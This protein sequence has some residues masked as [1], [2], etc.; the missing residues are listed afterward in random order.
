MSWLALLLVPLALYLAYKLVGVAIK[1]VL[2]VVLVVALYWWAAPLMGWPTVS[3]LFYVFGPDFEG[4]RI[5]EVVA[6]SNLAKRAKE[7]V[8]DDVV[9]EVISRSGLARLG[10][11]DGTSQDEPV[12]SP[13]H[14][15]PLPEPVPEPMTDVEG[16]QA[17]EQD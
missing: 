16:S 1:I 3:D 4:Q 8:V 2:A 5:E 15:E 11:V 13:P 10:G 14:P 6:P 12:A 17:V 7:T 9:G